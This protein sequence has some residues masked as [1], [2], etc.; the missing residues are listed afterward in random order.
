M[1][2][3]GK[4]HWRTR[5]EAEMK[6]IH[7]LAQKHYWAK[8]VTLASYVSLLAVLTLDGVINGQP[9]SL[10]LFTLIPLLIFIPVLRKE[11]YKGLSLL[12]FV[13]LM[14]FMV[15]VV[16]LF[17]PDRSILD[18]AELCLEVTLFNSAM[19]YSRWQQYSL[20]QDVINE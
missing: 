2:G 16:N 14:Y 19:L 7:K 6:T 5:P 18:I 13:L 3:T 20:Y 1:S 12:C 11:S 10:L 15:T 4:T 17:S 9:L 8:R